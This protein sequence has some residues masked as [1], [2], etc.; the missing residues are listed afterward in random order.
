MNPHPGLSPVPDPTDP[1][2]VAQQSE[3]EALYRH[4]LA[5]GALAVLLPTEDLENPCLRTLLGDILADLILGN[6]ISGKMCEGRFLWETVSKLIIEATGQTDE[7]TEGHQEDQLKKFGLLT[8][9]EEPKDQPSTL[10]ARA[11]AWIWSFLHFVYLAYVA[12]SFIA[13]GLGV[14]STASASRS[15]SA[16]PISHGNE[17]PRLPGGATGKRPVLNYRVYGMISQL[18][19]VPRRMPWLTGMLALLQYMI[20]AGPG[21]LGDTD[22]NLDR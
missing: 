4:T 7:M 2:T 3:N 10:Q 21:R 15:T 14:T 11:S 19:D 1:I 13:T 20:L 12:L 6:E 5:H 18:M 22:S 16:C 17:A 8:T 9:E